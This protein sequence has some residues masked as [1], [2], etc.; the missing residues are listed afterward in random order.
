MRV[1]IVGAGPAGLYLARLLQRAGDDH[2]VEVFEQ[3]IR[4]A[5]WGFGVGL[6]SRV[7]REIETLDPSV[8]GAIVAAMDFGARQLIRLEEQDFVIEYPEALGAIERLQLLRILAD[9]AEQSGVRLHY[10][11]RE[12]DVDRLAAEY[13]LVVAADGIGSSLRAQR[14]AAFGTS[15]YELTNRFAWYGVTS[16]LH[17]M[18]LVF[19]RYSGGVFIGHYYAYNAT[20]STF[21]AECDAATWSLFGMGGMLDHE[22]KVLMETVFAREL[23]GQPLIENRSIWRRFPVVANQRW[24]DG[25]LVLLGD[26]LQSAHFSIGSGTR[27]AMEDAAALF[28]A[29]K[30]VGTDIV[31]ALALFEAIR[32]PA[33]HTFGEAARKSFEWYERISGYM[34]QP[35]LDFIYDFLTRTGRIDDARLRTYAP[36]FVEAFRK[37]QAVRVA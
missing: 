34:D 13:D 30:Q 26:A 36:N 1:A 10:N 37:H 24:S 27:L 14:R 32:R 17:P 2:Q 21:V 31:A 15:A 5:T 22:R 29:I 7:M 23:D 18:A 12:E 11:H 9:A 33:R 25:N 8:H 4:A 6:G 3:G 19:R 35:I 28:A 20:M 16:A